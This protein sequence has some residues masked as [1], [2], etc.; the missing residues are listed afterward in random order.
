MDHQ[1]LTINRKFINLS[2]H[3]KAALYGEKKTSNLHTIKAETTPGFKP[4]INQKSVAIDRSINKSIQEGGIKR[5]DV[6]HSY[7]QRY[8]Q[9]KDLLREMYKQRETEDLNFEPEINPVSKQLANSAS[10]SFNERTLN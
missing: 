8:N 1:V 3:R 4:K 10:G 7:H 5:T 9:H 2:L 6:M